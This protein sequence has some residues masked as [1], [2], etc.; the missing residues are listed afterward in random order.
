MPSHPLFYG[1]LTNRQANAL[2][3]AVAVL[4]LGVGAIRYWLEPNPLLGLACGVAFYI[5]I[6]IN[7]WID[8]HKQ[9]LLKNWTHLSGTVWIIAI[10]FGPHP[11]VSIVSALAAAFLFV[12]ASKLSAGRLLGMGDARLLVVLAG[13]NGLWALPGALMML[14]LSFGLHGLYIIVKLLRRRATLR[15]RHPLGPWLVGGSWLAW[16]LTA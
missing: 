5:P 2:S 1:T 11:R 4:T 9:V 15:D 6:V 16:A 8:A 7:A 3:L 14:A 13:W 10:F 12:G